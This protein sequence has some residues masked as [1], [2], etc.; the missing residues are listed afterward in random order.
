L[1]PFRMVMIAIAGGTRP[2]T[3][4][5]MA[6]WHSVGVGVTLGDGVTVGDA[7]GVRVRVLVRVAV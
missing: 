1:V 6:P 7:V 4:P 3:C 2:E 5:A